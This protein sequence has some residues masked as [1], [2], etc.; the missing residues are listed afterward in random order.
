MFNKRTRLRFDKYD[1]AQNGFYFVTI[2]THNRVNCLGEIRDGVMVLNDR[3][4]VVQ[5]VW[6]ELPGHYPNCCVDEHV[7]MPNHVHGIIE[8]NNNNVGEGFKP[9]PT[10]G[11]SEIIRAFK[12]FSSRRINETAG[13]KIF[14][15]QRGFYDHI[16]RNEQDLNRVREYIQNNPM[17]WEMD[18]E[19]VN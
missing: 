16:I 4:C 13:S 10:H 8:I 5:R 7:I 14:Q 19:N 17:Q 18:E 11:L 1:Y 12:T 2:S 6:Y 15:W 9:S 3:G